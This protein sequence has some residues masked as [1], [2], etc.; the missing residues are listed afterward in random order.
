MQDQKLIGPL[1]MAVRAQ[2]CTAV[3]RHLVKACGLSP[4]SYPFLSHDEHFEAICQVL[5]ESLLPLWLA[6]Q[7]PSQTSLT[8][9][10]YDRFNRQMVQDTNGG[11]AELVETNPVHSV[12][13]GEESL[14]AVVTLYCNTHDNRE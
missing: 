10:V 6:E 4:H 12:A 13:P 3:R 2:L 7:C 8:C 1:D 11:Y 14:T 9:I 5:R